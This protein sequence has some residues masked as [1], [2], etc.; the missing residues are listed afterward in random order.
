MTPTLIVEQASPRPIIPTQAPSFTVAPTVGLTPTVTSQTLTHTAIPSLSLP[1]ATLEFAAVAQTFDAQTEIAAGQTLSVGQTA[2]A[3]RWTI[4]PTPNITASLQ[5]F[6]T[7]RAATSTAQALV[8]QSATA[9]LRTKT[10][11]NTPSATPTA[12]HTSTLAPTRTPTITPSLTP[13]STL[14]STLVPTTPIP[15]ATLT[16]ILPT[17][18]LPIVATTSPAVAVAVNGSQWCTGVN[19][20]FFPGGSQGGT[21]ESVVYNGAVQATSDLGPTTQYVWSNWDVGKMI[22]DFQGAMASHPDGIAIMGHPGDDALKPLVDQAEKAGIVVT[23]Q[24]VSLPQLESTYTTSGFGYA[25]AELYPQGQSVGRQAVTQFGLKAG[26]EVLVWGLAAQPGRGRRTV[27][28]ED[29]LK[30]A[31]IRV[32]YLEISDAIERDV[33]T[34]TPIFTAFMASHPNV[35]AVIIDHGNLTAALPTMLQAAGK[36]PGQIKTA[37]FDLIATTV[38]GIQDGWIGFANDQQ[39]WLQ[40]YLPILQICLTKKYGFSG[41]HIDTGGGFVDA[42]NVDTLAELI[43]GG[44]R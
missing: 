32:D 33:T 11:T 12:T 8:R 26:D 19:I 25:G 9:T 27:G 3:T 5:A 2:T 34:G 10:P 13:T 18:A 43:N 15:T 28:V 29:A 4:T 36:K 35:K 17:A 21:F 31:N 37:G 41:L 1:S 22:T 38:K 6:L 44:F 23:S 30:A 24:N 20:V 16:P 42:T 39:Q 40:G 7:A 14:T